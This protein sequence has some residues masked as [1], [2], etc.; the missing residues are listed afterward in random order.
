[1]LEWKLSPQAHTATSSSVANFVACIQISRCSDCLHFSTFHFCSSHP[2]A[3]EDVPFVEPPSRDYFC[4]VTYEV[5]DR[6][7]LTLCC[8]QHL[9]EN[10]SYAPFVNQNWAQYSIST[11]SV[12]WNHSGLFVGIREGDVSGRENSLPLTIIQ[13]L[14]L[15]DRHFHTFQREQRKLCKQIKLVMLRKKTYVGVPILKRTCD[16]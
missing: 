8:G 14:V 1:M 9:S 12:K 7:H 11:S 3:A 2:L 16:N 15:T 10:W 4:P 6:P 13:N 5:M